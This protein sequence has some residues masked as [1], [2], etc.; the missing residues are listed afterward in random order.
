MSELSANVIERIRR[1]RERG[2]EVHGP[3]PVAE[4]LIE[5]AAPRAEGA[6]YVVVI[7]TPSGAV[8]E[9]ERIDAEDAA[10]QAVEAVERLLD[11]VEEASIESFPASDPPGF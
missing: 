2:C 7:R 3:T 9:E 6:A 4:S 8:I 11:P 5:G 10:R 1:V